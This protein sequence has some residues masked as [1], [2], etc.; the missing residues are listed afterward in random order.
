M[1]QKPSFAQLELPGDRPPTPPDHFRDKENNLHLHSANTISRKAAALDG[2]A[3]SR[4]MPE[5]PPSSPVSSPAACLRTSSPQPT[6]RRPASPLSPPT[7]PPPS[8]PPSSRLGAS[9]K[10]SKQFMKSKKLSSSVHGRQ[11]RSISAVPQP[12]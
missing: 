12:R 1:D 2:N 6:L 9:F 11:T 5:N 4:R 7:T 8:P 10:F 3:R